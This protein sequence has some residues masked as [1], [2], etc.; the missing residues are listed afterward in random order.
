MGMNKKEHVFYLIRAYE[1]DFY[2]QGI[3]YA[4]KSLFLPLLFQVSFPLLL[5]ELLTYA[6]FT[7]ACNN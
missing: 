4:G 7:P 2:F 5:S 1:S 6:A 3:S